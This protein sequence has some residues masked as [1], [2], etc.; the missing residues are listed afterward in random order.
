MP[1]EAQLSAPVIL[2]QQD[3]E[4]LIHQVTG[5]TNLHLF[6]S[7]FPPCLYCK[8][9]F[10]EVFREERSFVEEFMV[11]FFLTSLYGVRISKVER[12]SFTQRVIS[13]R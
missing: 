5:C 12:D 13:Q 8:G 3:Q 11:I 6:S 1:P 10:V 2:V 4:N 7:F 9:V